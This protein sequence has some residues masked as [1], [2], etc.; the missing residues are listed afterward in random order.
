[1]ASLWYDHRCPAL[2]PPVGRVPQ[3]GPGVAQA[4]VGQQGGQRVQGVARDTVY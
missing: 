2:R 3:E 4:G 1:M